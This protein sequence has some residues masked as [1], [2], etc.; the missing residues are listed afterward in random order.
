[1][2]CFSGRF[3]QTL[4]VL[5]PNLL[6]NE[7]ENYFTSFSIHPILGVKAKLSPLFGFVY[8]FQDTSFYSSPKPTSKHKSSARK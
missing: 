6:I 8:F 4:I 2:F 7:V 5:P 1:M 3:V